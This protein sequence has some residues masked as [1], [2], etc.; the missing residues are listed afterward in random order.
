VA[1][2]VF[3]RKIV[4]GLPF[5]GCVLVVPVLQPRRGQLPVLDRVAFKWRST[6]VEAL[7]GLSRIGARCYAPDR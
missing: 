5:A 1:H 6:R 2:G 7:I 3:A 4:S